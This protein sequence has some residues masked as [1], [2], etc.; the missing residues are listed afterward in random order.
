MANESQAEL[1]ARGRRLLVVCVVIIIAIAITAMVVQQQTGTYGPDLCREGRPI[2]GHTVVLIDMTDPLAEA[3]LVQLRKRIDLVKRGIPEGA[4]LSV[5]FIDDKS[6]DMLDEQFCKCNPGSGANANPLISAPRMIAKKWQAS[7]GAPLD[8]ALQK[9]SQQ[10]T[11]RS[12]PIMEAILYVTE[13]DDFTQGSPGRQLIVV[14]D[15]IQNSERCSMYNGDRDF[16][17]FRHRGDSDD[18]IPDL[19]GVKVEV[20]YLVRPQY[21]A[22]QNQGLRDFWRGYFSEA[23]AA[24]P[25]RFRTIRGSYRADGGDITRNGG[26]G[27]TSDPGEPAAGLSPDSSEQPAETAAE[28]LPNEPEAPVA[29]QAPTSSTLTSMS[30]VGSGVGAPPTATKPSATELA[31]TATLADPAVEPQKPTDYTYVDELPTLIK[32]VPPNYPDLARSA[33]V[34][35]VVMINALIGPDGYVKDTKVLKSIPMLDAAAL[36]A[37]RRWRFKPGSVNKKPIHVW[38]AVPVR[39]RIGA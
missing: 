30:A 27:L 28:V 2:T 21:K 26:Q 1:D 23:H 3:E 24:A 29:P 8:S 6:A 33:G 9:A 39:F 18:M 4:K 11:S 36:E 37:V 12:S 15:M 10:L 16:G 14:S 25:V 22:F 5:F 7:F 32:Q 34:Q 38:V 20:D 19:N 13:R 31:S 35:G 17:K